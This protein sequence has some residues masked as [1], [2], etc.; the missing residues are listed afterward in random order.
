MLI[1]T[2]WSWSSRLNS[3]LVNWLPWSLLNTSGLPCFRAS[4]S[5]SAQ[6]PVSRV[7]DNRQATTYRL[8]QSMMAIR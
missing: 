7:L 4:P 6:K 3:R 1:F 2:R 5:A 8:C